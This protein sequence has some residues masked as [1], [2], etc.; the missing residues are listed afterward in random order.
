M[1]EQEKTQAEILQQQIAQMKSLEGSL[2][3][4]K[5]V[6][7]GQRIGTQEPETLVSNI[8]RNFN[9]PYKTIKQ[10]TTNVRT[11]PEMLGVKGSVFQILET[12]GN[13]LASYVEVRFNSPQA[14][15]VKMFLG[16]RIVTPF[17]SVWITNPAQPG[18]E[19]TYGI[20]FEFDNI[21]RFDKNF[22]GNI[23]TLSNI[24]NIDTLTRFPTGSTEVFA[25]V[26]LSN[27]SSA[28]L[29]TVGAGKTLHIIE[30]YISTGYEVA[31]LN[32]FTELLNDGVVFNHVVT[33]GT[34]GVGAWGNS[35]FMSHRPPITVLSGKSVTVLSE[36]A[37]TTVRKTDSIATIRGYLL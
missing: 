13:D 4:L 2:D 18:I 37:D 30:S 11:Y 12:T 5:T 3:A 16:D 35:S 36:S 17:N 8:I 20:G 32:I 28:S 19:F 25:S 14:S 26:R 7:L 10:D 6:L 1:P 21:F 23:G 22:S 15:P 24:L 27:V 33:H 31:A 29:Y 9:E 34:T